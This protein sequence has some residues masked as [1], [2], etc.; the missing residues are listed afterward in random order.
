MRRYR[1]IGTTHFSRNLHGFVLANISG[2]GFW[3]NLIREKSRYINLAGENQKRSEFV[4]RIRN[5]PLKRSINSGYQLKAGQFVGWAI[6]A[7]CIDWWAQ[8]TLL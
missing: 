4:L 5:N 7:N 3:I 1:G 6:A 2:S 8:P